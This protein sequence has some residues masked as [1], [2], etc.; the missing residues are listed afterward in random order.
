MVLLTLPALSP[1]GCAMTCA[2]ATILG[3]VRNRESFNNVLMLRKR[4]R[5][6]FLH[7]AVTAYLDH[8]GRMRYADVTNAMP[9]TSKGVYRIRVFPKRGTSPI[10]AKRPM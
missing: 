3:R 7:F 10:T 6:R 5:W 8:R 2:S 1:D 9:H 4:P